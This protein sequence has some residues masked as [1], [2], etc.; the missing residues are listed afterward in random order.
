MNAIRDEILS[1]NRNFAAVA[2]A[3]RARIDSN[4]GFRTDAIDIVD[5]LTL[6][7]VAER[8]LR[9]AVLMAVYLG[10]VRLIDSVAFDL[11]PAR[12]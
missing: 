3:A 11:P 1:G 10:R 12:D 9:A 6:K 2:A 4:A 8:T 5:A 7:P